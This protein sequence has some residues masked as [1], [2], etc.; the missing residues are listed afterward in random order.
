MVQSRGNGDDGA[1]GQEVTLA[2]NF[3]DGTAIHGLV[4]SARW[5]QR[6][7]GELAYVG[8]GDGWPWAFEVSQTASLTGSG[9]ARARVSGTKP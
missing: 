4:S 2:A 1:G 8:G 7:I 3:P 5:A 6:S 9:D